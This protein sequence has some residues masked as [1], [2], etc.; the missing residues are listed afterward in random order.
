ME[1]VDVCVRGNGAVGCALALALSRQGLRVVLQGDDGARADAPPERRADVRAFALNAGSV[2]LLRELKVWDA[3]PADARTAV[4]D[5]QIEG[6]APGAVLR[7]SAWS[8]GVEALA[9]I[10]DAAEL[11]RALRSALSF[12]PHVRRVGAGTAVEA[13]LLA[14]ADGK[15]SAGRA[16]LHVAMPAQPSG[17]RAVAARLVA[18]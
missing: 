13:T 9:W 15:D 12:A 7:F 6:D 14:L 11:E 3:L 5:M 10:V 17:Q 4:H 8:Q 1:A 18:E 2:A 16:Q